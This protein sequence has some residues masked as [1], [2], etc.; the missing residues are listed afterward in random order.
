VRKVVTILF[1]DLAGSTSLQER[2]DAET[3][4]RVMDRIHHLLGNAV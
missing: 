3:T 1:T 4:R 2:L